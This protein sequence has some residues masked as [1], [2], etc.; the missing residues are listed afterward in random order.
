[1]EISICIKEQDKNYVHIT[2]E[3]AKILY[4]ALGDLFGEDITK[5]SVNKA[6]KLGRPP[7]RVNLE[8]ALKLPVDKLALKGNVRTRILHS[9]KANGFLTLGDL[10]KETEHSLSKIANM[11]EASVVSTLLALRDYGIKLERR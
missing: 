1:M 4:K 2:L 3:E 5:P 6:K 9:L 8:K 10:S 7:T 11:G